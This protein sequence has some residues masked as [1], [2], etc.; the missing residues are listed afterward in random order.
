MTF[1]LVCYVVGA[2][3]AHCPV[4]ND[5]DISGILGAGPRREAL[6][7]LVSFRMRWR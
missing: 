7:L 3:P 5:M 6:Y 1:L 4:D 2:V